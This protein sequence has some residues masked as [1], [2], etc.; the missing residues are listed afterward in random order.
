MTHSI[1]IGRS[2]LSW[3]GMSLGDAW[4][5]LSMT[6]WDSVPSATDSTHGARRQR[7]HG[8]Q[9]AALSVEKRGCR[10]WRSA[11]TSVLVSRRPVWAGR[12]CSLVCGRRMSCERADTACTRSVVRWVTNATR[13]GR[14]LHGHVVSGRGRV[15]LPRSG[16][17]AAVPEHLYKSAVFFTQYELSAF[18]L[19]YLP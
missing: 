17:A 12:K 13:K 4:M 7:T 16:L 6:A 19:K 10:C 15:S 2:V 11:A 14:E 9:I 1:V 5:L 3:T 18:I 8:L